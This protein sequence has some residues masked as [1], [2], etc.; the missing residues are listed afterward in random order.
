[1]KVTKDMLEK[2][3][4]LMNKLLK[5]NHIEK[6]YE[7]GYRNGCTMLDERS[8]TNPDCIVRSIAHGTKTEVSHCV[9]SICSVL[10]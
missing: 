7:L 6:E 9:Q 1:M 8:Q 4:E 2:Q 3:V 10:R 5:Y